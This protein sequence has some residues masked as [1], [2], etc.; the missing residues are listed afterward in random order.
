MDLIAS[1]ISV[2]PE[3]AREKAK[4]LIE[5]Y[6]PPAEAHGSRLLWRATADGWKRTTISSSVVPHDFPAP[7]HD[8]LEQVID[9]RVPVGMI[10][11]LAQFD[12]SLVVHRTRGELAAHC[13]VPEINVSLVNLAH[14][15]ITGRRTV[16]E[17]R[18][19][20]TR[21]C[22]ASNRGEKAAYAQAF[23]FP[24]PHGGTADADVTTV[25]FARVEVVG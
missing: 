9:Y 10:S 16:E 18:A 14:D 21:L 3:Y 24:V 17:A 7:H 2:W 25:S 4:G 1:I 20:H 23:Q 6:G 22:E 8:C 11:L 12:G 13:P 19:E 15:I 5:R